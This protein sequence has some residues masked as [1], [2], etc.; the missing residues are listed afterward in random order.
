MRGRGE[1]IEP[2]A[3]EAAARL[4][5]RRVLVFRPGFAVSTPWAYGRLAAAAPRLYVPAEEAEARLGGWLAGG[6]PAEALLFNSM[7][8][9]AFPKFPALPCLLEA[10]REAFGLA[11][12]MSGSGSACFALL[13]EAA[14]AAPVALAV[15]RAWGPSA[16]VVETRIS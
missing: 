16:L 11:C 5:G 6:A 14:D 7:E 2:L 12:V 15:R 10:L 13:P 4:S 3:P 8:R 9:A 1:R